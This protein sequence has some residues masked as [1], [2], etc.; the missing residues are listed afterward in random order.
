M[1][2]TPMQAFPY[3][4]SADDPDVP[5]DMQA[6]A[7]AVEKRVFGIYNDATDRN[8]KITAPV[9]GQIAYLKDT[10]II[11]VHNGAAWVQVYPVV[12]PAF[13][14][15]TAVPS[16]GTGADGDVYFRL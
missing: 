16:N 12:V 11:T 3:P 13:T 14:S 4:T 2:T 7:V 8:A 5:G 10:D 6:L 9:E 15:G 1:A